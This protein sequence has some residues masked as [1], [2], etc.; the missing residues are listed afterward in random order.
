MIIGIGMFAMSPITK[1]SMFNPLLFL[2]VSRR[3]SGSPY[4]QSL[5][6]KLHRA[7]ELLEP[8]TVL[9]ED[10]SGGCGANFYVLVESRVFKGLPRI[11]QHRIVQEVLKDDIAKWHAVSIDTRVPV[12]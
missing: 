10:R 2:N 5:M 3:F 6:E 11:K 8:T 4:E 1:R 12:S 7:P 9:V